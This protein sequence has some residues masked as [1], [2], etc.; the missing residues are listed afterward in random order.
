MHHRAAAT[1]KFLVDELFF[2]FVFEMGVE[3]GAQAAKEDMALVKNQQAA[4]AAAAISQTELAKV[5]GR[6][7]R[8]GR[9]DRLREALAAEEAFR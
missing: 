4:T 6:V 9:T 1:H 2:F 3:A 8:V 5:G 7:V